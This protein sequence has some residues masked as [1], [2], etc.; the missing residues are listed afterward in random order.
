MDQRASMDQHCPRRVFD[1]RV[2]RRRALGPAMRTCHAMALLIAVAV[3]TALPSVY[4]QAAVADVARPHAGVKSKL[5]LCMRCRQVVD[6]AQEAA[7]FTAKAADALAAQMQLGMRAKARAAAAAAEREAGVAQ[8]GDPFF[9]YDPNDP[10]R[11]AADEALKR[12]LT[13]A[14]PAKASC[15]DE[16]RGARVTVP[17]PAS[18]PGVPAGA[19]GGSG[20]VT[21]REGKP[22]SDPRGLDPDPRRPFTPYAGGPVPRDELDALAPP[23]FHPDGPA[24]LLEV[25]QRAGEDGDGGD[26]IPL[27]PPAYYLGETAHPPQRVASGV[28]VLNEMDLCVN[29]GSRQF[30]YSLYRGVVG[31]AGSIECVDV[32]G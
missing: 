3:S 21:M 20:S 1:W 5:K 11:V 15:I 14:D 32:V 22:G 18:F 31:K 7:K 8:T 17:D 19:G 12:C 30:A 2:P 9:G 10:A 29:E 16:V 25:A 4:A 24:S 23:F 13:L 6:A 26:S 27:P 28:I